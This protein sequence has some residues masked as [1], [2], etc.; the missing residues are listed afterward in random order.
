MHLVNVRARL[1]NPDAMDVGYYGHY[2]ECDNDDPE[3]EV[4]VVT[5]DMRCYRC[6]GYGHWASD[7][8]TPAKVKGKNKGFKSDGTGKGLH[9]DHKGEGKGSK[10]DGKGRGPTSAVHPLRETWTWP[11][12]LLDVALRPDAVQKDFVY[13]GGRCGRRRIWFRRGFCGRADFTSWYLL[14]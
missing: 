6:Q 8:A 7:C 13:R 3:E 4:G 12:Q 5:E 10:G 1:R 11:G 9:S 14:M 2:E